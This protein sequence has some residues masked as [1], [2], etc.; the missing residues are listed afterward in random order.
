MGAAPPTERRGQTLVTAI[1]A[2]FGYLLASAW[3]TW[4]LCVQGRSVLLRGYSDAFGD[5]WGIWAASHG[6]RTAGATRL[7]SAPFG[8]PDIPGLSQP[9]LDA[10]V[11][12]LGRVA[13]DVAGYNLF[14][15]LSFTLTAFATFLFLRALL[16][17]AVPAFLGGLIFG[18]CP[19]AVM[20]SVGGHLGFALNAF[21]PLLVWALFVNRA[22]RDRVSALMVAAAYALL[23]LTSFYLGYFAIYLILWFIVYDVYSSRPARYFAAAKN[24]LWCASFAGGIILLF[25]YKALIALMS[26]KKAALVAGGYV[27]GLAESVTLSSRPWEFLIPSIDHPVFGR[28]VEDFSRMHLHGSN[29]DEQTLYLGLVPLTLT[30]IGL[31]AVLQ[32]RIHGERARLFWFFA[33]G[34]A[35]MAVMSGPPYVPIGRL[36]V[37]MPSYL[38]FALA[39]KFRAVCRFGILVDF[40]IA[41]TAAVSLSYLS[42]RMTRSRFGILSA[43]LVLM[44]A[45]EYWAVS[46]GSVLAVDPPPPAYQWLSRQPGDFLIAEYPMMPADEAAFGTYLFWQRVHGKRMVNGASKMDVEAWRLY[47]HVQDWGNP[48]TVRFLKEVGVRYVLVHPRMYA[49]GQIPGPLK[50]YYPPLTASWTYNGGSPPINPMM[51]KPWK[52]LGE[53]WIF[54]L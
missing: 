26:M 14:L 37:P 23:T 12:G 40:F 13:G 21:V 22:R 45:F 27:R 44:T 16:G 2:F 18:F 19:A 28:F 8:T 10:L 3:L 51:P 50:R 5:V 52:I 36:K 11:I 25:E 4:P 6:L 9:V 20:H 29:I 24:Y 1:L 30:V 33:A 15:F 48:E 41:G 54:S 31:I 39:S 17:R 38:A 43:A 42:E 32:K 34:A 35:L 53:D 46:P 49:E 7:I 47:E